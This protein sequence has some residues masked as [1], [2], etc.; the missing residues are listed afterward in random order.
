MKYIELTKDKNDTDY[1]QKYINKQNALQKHKANLRQKYDYKNKKIV[2]RSKLSQKQLNNIDSDS[3]IFKFT[4]SFQDQYERDVKKISQ[5][6]ILR[7]HIKN[8]GDLELK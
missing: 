2:D 5:E 1:I 4:S 8:W 7:Q 3:T 6:E